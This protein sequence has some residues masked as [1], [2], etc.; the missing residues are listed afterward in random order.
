MAAYSVKLKVRCDSQGCV[1][2]ATEEVFDTW[3][4][5]RGIYCTPHAKAWV[6]KWNDGFNKAPHNGRVDDRINGG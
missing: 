2:R 1:K 3:N 6:K 5:Q 4:G